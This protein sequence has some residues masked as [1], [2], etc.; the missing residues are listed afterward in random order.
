LQWTM[1]VTAGTRYIAKPRF[2]NL[3][4]YSGVG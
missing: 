3:E 4:L 2:C 1:P